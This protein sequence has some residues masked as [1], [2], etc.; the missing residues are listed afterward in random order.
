MTRTPIQSE[1]GACP[2]LGGLRLR[3]PL[4][5]SP[6]AGFTNLPFRTAIRAMGGLSVATTDLVNARSLLELN[7]KA[8][9]MV[10]ACSDDRPL[11][12]QLFGADKHE[13]SAAARFLEDLGIDFI[14]IN[15]GCPSDKVTKNGAGAALMQDE[16]LTEELAEAVVKAVRLPVT[17]KMRLGWDERSINAHEIA[18]RLEAMGVAA[19]AVH[20]RT[21]AQAY[22][23]KVN[24]EGIRAVVQ[25]VKRIPVIG[26]G[27]VHSPED[28]RRMIREIGC[29]AV[30]V[31]RAA[32]RDPFFFRR[33]A[34]F[35]EDGIERPQPGMEATL[36]FMHHHFVLTMKYLGE[37]EACTLFRKT[38][39]GYSD[40]FPHRERWRVA[41]QHLE[42]KEEYLEL[43][44]SL[45]PG[46]YSALARR[47]VWDA[48][49]MLEAV[50]AAVDLPELEPAGSTRVK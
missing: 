25:S 35:L 4:M 24:L 49:V 19:V 26:N 10:T 39:A 48:G 38:V 2:S 6:M 9:R 8:V 37:D 5:L 33:T 22:S 16:E 46:D 27:D 41:F 18:P 42:S 31:G 14:D 28:A 30:M 45:C 47:P 43:L 11:G 40:E 15:L 17:V 3:H 23:G 7:P 44:E 13:L 20:G 12:V 36:L 34:L 50:R 32:L 29:A 21:K 1:S